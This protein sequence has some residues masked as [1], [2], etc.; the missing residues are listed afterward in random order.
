MRRINKT[1][2]IGPSSFIKTCTKLAVA[3]CMLFNLKISNAT[4]WWFFGFLL[5]HVNLLALPQHQH[6]GF[7]CPDVSDRMSFFFFWK[8]T[9]QSCPKR[10][11]KENSSAGAEGEL[12]EQPLWCSWYRQTRF[13]LHN[14]WA[15]RHGNQPMQQCMVVM[16]S[17]RTGM[18]ISLCMTIHGLNLIPVINRT[19]QRHHL[20]QEWNTNTNTCCR[21]CG[22][23]LFGLT[24]WGCSRCSACGSCTLRHSGI[25]ENDYMAAVKWHVLRHNTKN[26]NVHAATEPH[27]KCTMLISRDNCMQRGPSPPALIP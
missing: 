15:W 25:L 18:Q 17:F 26:Q 3:P 27:K 7:L 13:S 20:W 5:G 9:G 16:Q 12:K 2:C 21:S 24:R 10:R 4:Q 1:T 8:R 6:T 11:D 22:A 14:R 19:F 23:L